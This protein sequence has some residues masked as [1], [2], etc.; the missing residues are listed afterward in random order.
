MTHRRHTKIMSLLLAAMLVMGSFAP[1]FADAGTEG[2]T[3]LHQWNEWV[4][5]AQPT[6]ILYGSRFHTCS[7]CGLT[8]TE[9]IPRIYAENVWVTEGGANYYLT[10]GGG[11]ATGWHKIRSSNTSSKVKWCYFNEAGVFIKSISKNTKSKWVT[12]GGKK[13]YFTKKKKPAGQGFNQIND[14]LYY[15]GPDKAMV[16]GTFVAT[17]G[18]TYTTDNKGRIKG[19]QFYKKKYKTFV[20]IDLSDQTLTYYK[21]KKKVMKT[22]I[23]SGSRGDRATPTGVF[24]LNGKAMNVRLKG[25]TWDVRV[26]Y[27]MPFIGGAYG[28]HD[29]WWRAESEYNSKTYLYNGSHGCINMKPSAAKKLYKKI[30][31]GTK[32]IVQN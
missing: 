1:V 12:A 11:I 20:L 14:N 31:I 13:F 23:V 3:C 19:M 17:D 10:S 15:M 30:K 6:Y 26:K 25:S 2:S 4:V 5:T 27:W 9:A 22:K 18:E 7:L 32:V 24:T 28:M 16:I 8:E 29:S 21:N